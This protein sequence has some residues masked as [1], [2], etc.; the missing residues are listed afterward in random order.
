MEEGMSPKRHMVSPK[1]H[2]VMDVMTG[3]IQ[4][5]GENETVDE[6][7]NKLD[8]LNVAALPICGEDGTLRGMI[9]ERDII[10]GVLALTKAPQQ[11]RAGEVDYEEAEPVRADDSLGLAMQTMVDH[12]LTTLPVIDGENEEPIGVINI[13]DV[14]HTA[15]VFRPK[16][17]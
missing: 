6:V 13:I 4:C 8:Q 15:D 5:V 10:A 11:I 12:N 1:R 14:I 17:H 3:E 2:K 16:R 7:A 9:T